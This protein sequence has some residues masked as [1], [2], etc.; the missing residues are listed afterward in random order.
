MSLSKANYLRT[1]LTFCIA[2]VWLINGLFCKVL[3]LVPRHHLIVARILGEPVSFFAV[4]A[5]GIL[6]IL[7][8]VW[9]VSK[10][11]SKWCALT[12]ILVVGTMNIIEFL[13]APDLLLFGKMNLLLAFLFMGGVYFNEFFLPKRNLSYSLLN[14]KA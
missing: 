12:Q 7:M 2:T 10:I 6:E 9:I 1:I 4:K 14:F 11:K 13:L 8:V 5:I 3:N